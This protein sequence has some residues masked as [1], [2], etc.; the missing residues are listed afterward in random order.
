M[1]YVLVLMERWRKDKLRRTLGMEAD[2]A[3]EHGMA[4]VAN[5]DPAARTDNVRRSLF[6]GRQVLCGFEGSMTAAGWCSVV[7]VL[8][9]AHV[10]HVRL[11]CP[12]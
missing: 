10:L 2:P 9:F 3:G 1:R 5:A 8:P 12:A 4:M 7:V 6:Q 11:S